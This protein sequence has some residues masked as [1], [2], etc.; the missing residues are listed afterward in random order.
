M[1]LWEANHSYYCSESNFFDRDYTTE[2]NSWEEF[3]EAEDDSDDDLNLVFR[4][5]WKISNKEGE[6]YYEPDEPTTHQL[7]L[8]YMLQR[9]GIYRAVIV[10]VEE[11]DEE[12]IRKWLAPKYQKMLEIWQPFNMVAV[13]GS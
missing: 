12:K 5:D 1:K 10:D 2:Y 6:D 8:C 7:Q 4:W 9:K 3:I 13:A 11:D